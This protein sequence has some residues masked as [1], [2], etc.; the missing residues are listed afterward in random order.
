MG[1]IRWMADK[2]QESTGE[3]D[4]RQKVEEVKGLVR[5]YKNKVTESIEELNPQIEIFNGKIEELNRTRESDVKRDISDLSAFLSKYGNCKES[6]DYAPE[7]G[8]IPAV[9]PYREQERL[10]TY[11]QDVDW[12]KSDVFWNSFLRTPLGMQL[13]TRKQNYS[14]REQIGQLSLKIEQTVRELKNQKY[15]TLLEQEICEHYNKNVRFISSFIRHHIIPEIELV[16]AFF[17]A[18]CISE[19][20]AIGE[21]QIVPKFSY[22][23]TALIGTPYEKHYTFIRNTFLFY[24]L[25]CRIYDTP[26]LTNL[27]MRTV[28]ENDKLELQ[29]E[30]GLLQTGADE[31]SGA[32]LL[33]RGAE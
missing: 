23:I 28:S 33:E 5:D 6:G 29:R 21:M 2:V 20:V 32:M 22:D 12:S 18:L 31:V 27:F 4:R 19:H 9:F 16:D 13:K 25:S 17:Q 14:M 8:K 11:V 3:K 1:L 7:A 15:T 30:W 10:E 24:I 26:V